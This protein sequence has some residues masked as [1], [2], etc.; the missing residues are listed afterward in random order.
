MRAVWWV[1]AV[2]LV[3]A[4]CAS[5][6]AAV[7]LFVLALVLELRDSRSTRGRHGSRP[8]SAPRSVWPHSH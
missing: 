3:L 5:H 6:T 7:L 8:S 2:L 1:V 4:A